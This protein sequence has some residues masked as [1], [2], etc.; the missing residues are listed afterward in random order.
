MRPA[1]AGVFQEKAPNTTMK[2]QTEAKKY[3]TPEEFI[4]N[5]TTD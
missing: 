3:N 5:Q 1:E 4:K 2:L